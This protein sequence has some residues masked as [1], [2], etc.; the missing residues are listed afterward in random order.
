[1]LAAPA[2]AALAEAL[3]RALLQHVAAIVAVTKY[4]EGVRCA[5]VAAGS[6]PCCC[7]LLCLCKQLLQWR[8]FCGSSQLDTPKQGMFVN[9]GLAGTSQRGQAPRHSCAALFALYVIPGQCVSL[10]QQIS[11]LLLLVPPASARHSP[12]QLQAT[13]ATARSL[14][15]LDMGPH[16]SL[17]TAAAA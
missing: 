9:A 17:H 10:L 7:C 6:W 13:S 1:L 4:V 5:V 15:R 16:L 8:W 3:H 14:N 11:L 12:I 2:P